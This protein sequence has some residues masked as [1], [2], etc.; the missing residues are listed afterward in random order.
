MVRRAR[1][2]TVAEPEERDLFRAIF[3]AAAI[4][5]IVRDA[6]GIFVA[7]NRACS[8]LFGLGMA[9]FREAS[10]VDLTHPDDRE[11]SIRF[12]NDLLKSDEQSGAIEKRYRRRDGSVIWARTSVSKLTDEVGELSRLVVIIQ[13]L[14]AR[15]EAEAELRRSEEQVRQIAENIHD[16]FWLATADYTQVLYLS[17]AIEEIWGLSRERLYEHAAAGVD[18]VHPDDL[19][20]LIEQARRAR[21][22]PND[23]R[24]RIVHPDGSTRWVRSRAFPIR[25]AAGETYRIAGVLEDLTAKHETAE[26]LERARRTAA[27]LVRAASEPLSILQS[28]L[29]NGDGGSH[30]PPQNGEAEALR[31]RY[32]QGLATLTRRERQ[33][34][35]LVVRGQSSREMARILDLAPKTIEGYRARV[36][37]KMQ[38]KSLAEL[39]RLSLMSRTED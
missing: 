38:V 31:Q 37:E 11:R 22:T 14:S 21:E 39:V 16:A 28:A 7:A 29:G 27:D 20:N 18:R 25:N 30:S 33:V 12:L 13:D 35:E 6:R 1:R 36:K 5:I 32:E 34:M 2:L 26:L 19:E 3:D 9:Q 15:R 4:P 17:P 8:E 24:M 10:F 23:F